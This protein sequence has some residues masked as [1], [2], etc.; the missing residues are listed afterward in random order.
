MFSPFGSSAL[1]RRVAQ[2]L[3]FWIVIGAPVRAQEREPPQRDTTRTRADS[4]KARPFVRGGVYDKPYQ[5]RRFGQTAI[6]GYAEAHARY[7]R[8]DGIRDA[9][10]FQARRLT[11]FANNQVSDLVRLAME[12]E[13]ENG[14]DEIQ[15]EFAAIDLRF[16]PA[17][18]LRGGMILSPLGKF[19][20]AHDSPMN[21]FTDRPLVATEL[22]GVT[23]AER[24]S[25]P[26][27]SFPQAPRDV[28]RMR[29]TPRTGSATV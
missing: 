5:T 6:G 29:C 7:E 13:F 17:F 28:S 11:L 14:T 3:L 19:N 8:I 1:G 23:L 25:A 16:H 15:M 12:L 22:L 26:L 4:A 10:G 20:L 2:L 18:A 27:A 24:D 9:A 21:E